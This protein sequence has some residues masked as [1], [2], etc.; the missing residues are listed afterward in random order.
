MSREIKFRVWDSY[1]KCMYSWEQLLQQEESGSKL[2]DIFVKR[3]EIQYFTPLQYSGAKDINGVEI[4]EG[5]LITAR[6]GEMVD[7]GKLI[8]GD[9]KSLY[10]VIFHDGGFYVN[11]NDDFTINKW[12]LIDSEIEVVGNVFESKHL[13]N[14]VNYTFQNNDFLGEVLQE[15]C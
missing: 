15:R 1:Q 11:K 2:S 8:R 12:V 9:F 7:G 14:Y 13:I 5:D 3:H 10:K 6:T 4:Y